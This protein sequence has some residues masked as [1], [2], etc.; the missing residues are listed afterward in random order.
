M[1]IFGKENKKGGLDKRY[2]KHQGVEGFLRDT[3]NQ[4]V[5]GI[6]GGIGSALVG[7]MSGDSQ[8]KAEKAR[9]SALKSYEAQEKAKAQR[10]VAEAEAER[11]RAETKMIENEAKKKFC[12]S[13]GLF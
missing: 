10:V 1:G 3:G 2:K 7:G 6:V 12:N 8:A 5:K 4:A 9:E 11:M 13:S